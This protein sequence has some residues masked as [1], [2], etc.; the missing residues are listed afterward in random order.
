MQNRHTERCSRY[1]YESGI[2]IYTLLLPIEMTKI[3]STD[4]P[5]SENVKQS[6]PS[7]TIDRNEKTVQPLSKTVCLSLTE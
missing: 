7:Y 3:K 1:H 4:N 5:V 2:Y 6:K